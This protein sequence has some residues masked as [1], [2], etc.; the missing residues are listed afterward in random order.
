[1]PP[2]AR[3]PLPGE[4]RIRS[5]RGV[6]T[7]VS[8]WVR[9]SRCARDG[10][11]PAC[12]PGRRRRCASA[13]P[14][15]SV[16][17]NSRAARS[18]RS[19]TSRPRHW[20]RK[21]R[22]SQAG[23]RRGSKWSPSSSTPRPAKPEDGRLPQSAERGDAHAAGDAG[24]RVL[25][26]GRG[27]LAEVALG[28]SARSPSRA[29]TMACMARL[30]EL[31]WP[32]AGLVV[33]EVGRVRAQVE[34]LRQQRLQH[35]HVRLLD[36]LR[37]LG[38]FAPEHHV[39]GHRP[40]RVLRQVD[41]LQ[42]EVARELLDAPGGRV[43]PCHQAR[44]HVAPV[45]ELGG[46]EAKLIA[47]R[48]PALRPTLGE[49]RRGLQPALQVPLRQHVGVGVVVNVLVVL[50]RPDDVANVVAARPP[51]GQPDWPRSAPFPAGSRRRPRAGTA[52]PRWPASTAT[53]R[54]RCRR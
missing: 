54:R 47:Q 26:V 29:A 5:G 53:P 43:E 21:R 8:E 50:V 20:T 51:P 41:V 25:Q 14:S 3:H 42:V 9:P 6:E 40:T 17:V 12:R 1:M 15:C 48:A 31:P 7:V 22:T 33:A 18:R 46:V 13:R 32:A 2:R 44:R 37:R 39:H 49:Q 35:D 16:A 34:A 45:R 4:R 28:Q 24:G 38:A 19:S 23:G 52:R 30:S 11:V 36:D 27:R 10:R